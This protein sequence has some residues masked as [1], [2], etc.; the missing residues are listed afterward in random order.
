[1]VTQCEFSSYIAG[2]ALISFGGSS[3]YPLLFFSLSLIYFFM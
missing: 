1:M 2:C 3:L